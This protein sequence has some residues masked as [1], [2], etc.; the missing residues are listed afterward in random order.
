MSFVADELASDCKFREARSAASADSFWKRD[1]RL[2]R[3]AVS[4]ILEEKEILVFSALQWVAIGIMYYVW[5]QFLGWIPPEVWESDD[6]LAELGIN[7]VFLAWSFACA[8]H[9]AFCAGL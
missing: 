6:D 7:L 2:V 1:A 9:T 3:S 8:R 4:L 5:V